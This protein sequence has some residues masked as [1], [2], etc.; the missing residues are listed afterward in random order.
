MP[1]QALFWLNSGFVADQARAILE[2]PDVKSL[3]GDARVKRLYALVYQRAPSRREL[4]AAREFLREAPAAKGSEAPVT[5]VASG[6]E[7]PA[8]KKPSQAAPKPLNPW[9]Q[10]AQVLLAANEFAFID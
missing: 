9:E 2:R 6:N 3:E 8:D 4:A 5:E 7:K 10:Y 1:Q